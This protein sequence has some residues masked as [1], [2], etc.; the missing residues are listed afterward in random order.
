M[1]TARVVSDG[2]D[3]SQAAHTSIEARLEDA[4]RQLDVGQR[5]LGVRRSDI[6]AKQAGVEVD[7]ILEAFHGS[8][9]DQP[10]GI[11]ALVSKGLLEV[12][13]EALQLR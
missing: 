11:G 10:S 9:G 1:W 8:G 13:R 3:H 4:G 5:S 7:E 2:V 12:A 6:L